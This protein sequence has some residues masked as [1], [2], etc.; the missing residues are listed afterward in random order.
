MPLSEAHERATQ[1]ER[2]L[3]ERFGENSYVGIHVEPSK[4]LW[5]QLE[6]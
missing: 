6:I 4:E 1:L 3:K 2:K 5:K